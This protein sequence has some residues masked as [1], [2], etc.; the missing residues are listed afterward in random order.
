MLRRAE[1]GLARHLES[2]SSSDAYTSLN[3]LYQTADKAA[4]RGVIRTQTADRK[5]SRALRRV[6]VLS[7]ASRAS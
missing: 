1:K 3:R 5:K 7:E 4:K 2:K 6:R